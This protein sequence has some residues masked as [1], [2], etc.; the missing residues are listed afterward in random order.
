VPEHA[1]ALAALGPTIHHR[2]SFSPVAA[3]QAELTGSSIITGKTVEISEL[4]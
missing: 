4:L 1:R 3:A 2:R